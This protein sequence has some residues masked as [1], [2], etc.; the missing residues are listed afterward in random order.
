MEEV[1]V[2]SYMLASA[3][4]FAEERKDPR[5]L[6]GLRRQGVPEDAL[7]VIDF[8]GVETEIAELEAVIGAM[9]LDERSNPDRIPDSRRAQIVSG[10]GVSID[11][12][13]NMLSQFCELSRLRQHSSALRTRR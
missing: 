3:R 11:K 4:R 13:Q 8:E 12:V 10:S 5:F 9:T 2:A 6:E 7:K 1:D